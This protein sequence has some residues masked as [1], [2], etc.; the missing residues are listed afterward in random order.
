MGARWRRV[1]TPGHT[2]I[3][4]GKMPTVDRM[5]LGPL[6]FRRWS[7]DGLQEKWIMHHLHG[8]GAWLLTDL[9]CAKL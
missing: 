7:H 8:D 6:H 2:A 3:L 9:R 4:Q 5:E 1:S